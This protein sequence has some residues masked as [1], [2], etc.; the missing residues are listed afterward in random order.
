MK[1]SET[2]G[3]TKQSSKSRPEENIQKIGVYAER[4]LDPEKVFKS[5]LP[6]AV[7]RFIIQVC[8]GTPL[9]TQ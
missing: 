6:K 1:G 3:A 8:N 4:R 7:K 9:Q 2:S 5:L